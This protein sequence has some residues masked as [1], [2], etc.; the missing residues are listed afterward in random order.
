MAT[1]SVVV[2]NLLCF[3]SNKYGKCAIRQLKSVIIDFYDVS[4]V[5][6]AKQQLI[7]DIKGMNLDVVMPH[8]PER[9]ESHNKAQLVV[10]DIFTLFTF[11]DE[12]LKLTMLPCYVASSPDL[13]P[14]S[15]LYEG[16]LHILMNLIQKIGDEMKEL[17][18]AMI[19]LAR[20]A[21]GSKSSTALHS[22]ELRSDIHTSSRQPVYATGANQPAQPAQARASTSTDDCETIVK[23]GFSQDKCT[24][25]QATGIDHSAAV[26]NWAAAVVSTPVL[27]NRYSVLQNRDDDDGSDGTYVH[28]ES[29]RSRKRRR[30]QSKQQKQL[31]QSRSDDANQSSDVNEQGRQRQQQQQLQQQQQRQRSRRVMVG[32][33]SPSSDGR[34]IDAAK[35]LV[36]KAVFCV[37]NV[38]TSYGVDDVRSFVL[39]LNVN[40]LSCFPAQP[41]RRPDERGPVTDRRAFRLCILESDRERLLDPRK[42]PDSVTV[43]EWYR[44]PPSVAA[45]KR[46]Q[47]ADRTRLEGA[48]ASALA[49]SELNS[50]VPDKSTILCSAAATDS[51]QPSDDIIAEGSDMDDCSVTDT[52]D[53]TVIYN[54]GITTAAS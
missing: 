19:D 48:T 6:G 36:K 16:D 51:L 13:M 38:R 1:D 40:V 47:A 27:H 23:S 44:M 5:C 9:R 32:N 12:N 2:S 43:S 4:D 26:S 46:R 7:D 50:V 39:G 14:S 34:G 30:H 8:V 54:N 24:V 21:Q 49:Q 53:A 25:N 18:I 15:R 41:R 10:D 45:E 33:K 22:L 31:Q 42:W 20:R 17:K 3:L 37:D 11:M 29:R 52:S 35:K 28:Y